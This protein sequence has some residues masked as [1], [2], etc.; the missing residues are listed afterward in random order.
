MD[1]ISALQ[2][3]GSG[4]D[5]KSGAQESD[6]GKDDFL[7][8]LVTQLK[9]QDPLK[10]SDPT[11]FTSQLAEFSS[12]EQLQNIKDG[13]ESLNDVENGFGRIEALSLIDKNVVAESNAFQFEGQPVE[14]GC[15]LEQSGEKA[16]INVKN[17]S[18]QV[19]DQIAVSDPSAGEHFFRWDG[20]DGDGKSMPTGRYHLEV[21]AAGKEGEKVNATPLVASR[22]TGADFS[23]EGNRLLTTSGEVM[24]SEVTRVKNP[25]VSGASQ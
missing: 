17:D 24:L 9:N 21:S 23:D 5:L 8:L 16:M 13:M 25:T 11:E 22:V 12:L 3:F 14:M 10:P 20:T 6:L 15:R 1:S 4:S 2:Q 18:G 19:V 7:N